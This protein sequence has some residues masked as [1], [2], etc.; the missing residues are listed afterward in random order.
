ME[1]IIRGYDKDNKIVVT[2]IT[3]YNNRFNTIN[4]IMDNEKVTHI[5][6]ATKIKKSV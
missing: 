6:T 5:T 4:E 3:D 2:K 1:T